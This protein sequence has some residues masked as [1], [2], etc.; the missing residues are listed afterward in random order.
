[1]KK[2][3]FVITAVLVALLIL[4]IVLT[5]RA[6]APKQS[7][8]EET[9]A[10]LDTT[11]TETQLAETEPPVEETTAPTNTVTEPVETVPQA[12]TAPAVNTG[13]YA[14]SNTASKPSSSTNTNTSNDNEANSSG[15]TVVPTATEPAAAET[16]N[17]TPI[18]T[19][20][21]TAPIVTPAEPTPT[22]HTHSWQE[23]YHEEVSHDVW[24]VTC[25]CGARF[26]TAEEWGAHRN[27]Y[28]G[29]DAS[30]VLAHGGYGEICETVVDTP[31]YSTW[32]CSGCGATSDTQP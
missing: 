18:P 12:T 9:I 5:L 8:G 14:N 13:N 3:D 32:V 23:I 4:A 19:P 10:T 1:M 15:T 29:S 24:W 17:V 30:I 27:S 7:D 28:L 16:P 11:P 22:E 31:A 6:C 25:K 2:K 21:P 26:T 20:A